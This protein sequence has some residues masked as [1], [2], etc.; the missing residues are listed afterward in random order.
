M[1]RLVIITALFVPLMGC[2]TTR[3]A[4]YNAW[5][6]MGYAKR[7]RLVDELQLWHERA[8]AREPEHQ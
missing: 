2:Q 7:E 1:L 3:T 8:A 5:E 4:Y 6:K